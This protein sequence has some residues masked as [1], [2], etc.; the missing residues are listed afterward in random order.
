M[1]FPVEAGHVMMFARAIG[2]PNPIYFDPEY[3]KITELGEIT[4][5]PTFVRASMQFEPRSEQRPEIGKAWIGSGRTPSGTHKDELAKAGTG[6]H[7]EQHFVYHR[8]L[9]I[10]D[11]LSVV[12]HEGRVWEREG[13][14]GGLLTFRETVIEFTNQRGELV[15][16]A[17]RVGVRTSRTV[18]GN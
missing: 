15:V 18:E 6:L 9:R 10:G 12:E 2:D 13:R 16:T 11:V 4:A 8:P 14:R 1:E 3:A 17:R 7:A 5:P